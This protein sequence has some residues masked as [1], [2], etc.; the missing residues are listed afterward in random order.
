MFG[1]ENQGIIHGY[2]LN[3]AKSLFYDKITNYETPYTFDFHF[4]G[5]L[6][7][8]LRRITL[9]LTILDP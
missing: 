4:F 1:F 3:K 2:Y 5:G 7:A 8:A 6:A 9:I